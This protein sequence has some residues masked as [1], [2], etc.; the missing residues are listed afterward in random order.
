MEK[1]VEK[2][3]NRAKMLNAH[4]ELLNFFANVSDEESSDEPSQRT[5]GFMR[6]NKR[7]A[8]LEKIAEL[9]NSKRLGYS[10]SRQGNG[11]SGPQTLK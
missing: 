8:D 2:A 10:Q 5:H 3:K 6:K 4:A 11:N 7:N 1:K 9:N